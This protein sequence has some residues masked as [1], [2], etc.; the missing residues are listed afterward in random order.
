MLHL[1]HTLGRE[2]HDILPFVR[3][4]F[5]RTVPSLLPAIHEEIAATCKGKFS[6]DAASQLSDGGWRT[7]ILLPTAVSMIS[8]ITCR[9]IVGEPLSR[10]VDFTHEAVEFT[11]GLALGL[12]ILDFCPNWMRGFVIRILPLNRRKKMLKGMLRGLVLS[13]LEDVE[14]S[15]ENKDRHSVCQ[16]FFS[17]TE[18]RS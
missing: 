10:N 7:V 16:L 15:E 13:C 17:S 9:V 2:I 1:Q 8:R 11:H 18:I 12:G 5:S 4:E 3:H 14:Q 6:F